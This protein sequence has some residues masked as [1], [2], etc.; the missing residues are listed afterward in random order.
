MHLFLFIQY[1]FESIRVQII[2]TA[3]YLINFHSNYKMHMG[4]VDEVLGSITPNSVRV[5]EGEMGKVRPDLEHLVVRVPVKITRENNENQSPVLVFFNTNY[6]LAMEYISLVY[7]NSLGVARELESNSAS[8]F[9]QD[10]GTTG[11]LAVRI[12]TK[13]KSIASFKW[14][15]TVCVN[16]EAT[17]EEFPPPYLELPPQSF[18]SY[19]SPNNCL[20]LF[21]EKIMVDKSYLPL[22]FKLS[23]KD[24]K[25]SL[26]S[27]Q[28]NSSEPSSSALTSIS[29]DVSFIIRIYRKVDKFLIRE[30]KGKELT[31]LYMISSEEIQRN[32]PEGVS[33]TV[34]SAPAP[35]GKD[36]KKD[37]KKDAKSASSGDTSGVAP[38][39]PGSGDLIE[40]I[41]DCILDKSE[42][43]VPD[44]WLVNYP[45]TF[46]NGNDDIN[47]TES[48][49]NT[50]CKFPKP[51]RKLAWNLDILGG[52]INDI[53]HDIETLELFAS[54]KNSWENADEGRSEKAR[55]AYAYYMEK[56]N[57]IQSSSPGNRVASDILLNSL[58]TVNELEI[59]QFKGDEN[60]RLNLPEVAY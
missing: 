53:S 3:S 23:I 10:V 39:V 33:L 49:Q 8:F 28:E 30:V 7:I 21:R 20:K 56:K 51:S 19:F 34:Q 50:V 5:R 59:E 55:A 38:P 48:E 6:R 29:Q 18:K 14:K 35:T 57:I 15:L 4:K 11:Y 32:L 47:S 2:S 45:F 31:Q 24:L 52:F 41:F 44:D 12:H 25:P 36:A 58:S 60:E 16:S 13:D 43:T 37:P 54:I 26:D 9:Y 27:D 46:D 1:I 40:L 42:M 22:A 17:L